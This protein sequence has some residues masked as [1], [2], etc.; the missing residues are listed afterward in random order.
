MPKGKVCVNLSTVSFI[1][2]VFSYTRGIMSK[3]FLDRISY[4][5]D[6]T[7]YPGAVSGYPAD[8]IAFVWFD[9]R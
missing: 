5:I 4:Y 6:T 1:L 2:M 8:C 7:N 3:F 9:R